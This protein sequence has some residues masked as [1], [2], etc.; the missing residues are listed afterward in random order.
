[1]GFG[2]KICFVVYIVSGIVR[3]D[4]NG[5]QHSFLGGV[6]GVFIKLACEP[7]SCLTDKIIFGIHKRVER[8]CFDDVHANQTVGVTATFYY[9]PLEG[10]Y[11]E[12]VFVVGDDILAIFK[13]I[14][15]GVSIGL[16]GNL[17]IPFTV[18]AE[19]VALI[20]F[21]I[22]DGNV[23]CFD[24]LGIFAKVEIAID[25][26]IGGMLVGSKRVAAVVTLAVRVIRVNTAWGCLA[27]DLR[28][29]A[30]GTDEL[31]DACGNARGGDDYFFVAVTVIA[32]IGADRTF[33]LFV[34]LILANGMV[35]AGIELV[36]IDAICAATVFTE[37]V[38]ADTSPVPAV[39]ALCVEAILTSQVT[40]FQF[41]VAAVA[42]IA[43][44]ASFTP[45]VGNVYR[46]AV[47]VVSTRTKSVVTTLLAK[48]LTA[49]GT[50]A[51][52]SLFADI[53]IAGVFAMSDT[54]FTATGA[55]FYCGN[56]VV[57]VAVAEV[58]VA[59]GAFC[60]VALREV[61]AANGTVFVLVFITIAVVI[62]VMAE[63]IATVFAAV[64]VTCNR[65]A[66]TA[67]V[68]T[69]LDVI[70]VRHTADSATAVWI[71]VAVGMVALTTGAAAS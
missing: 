3:A 39:S 63:E 28:I 54:F 1:M 9:H 60:M 45:I 62:E 14:V 24:G 59:I 38:S 10:L 17:Q 6:K 8:A 7:G 52:A 25:P 55:G 49:R 67:F 26:L 27:D 23:I 58:A 71:L 19:I 70:F 48:E 12:V 41:G 31:G 5:I 69:V 66:V 44:V 43:A 15:L 47:S 16:C 57:I 53:V 20:V 18:G 68:S 2:E 46:F 33:A 35:A 61:A 4:Y 65:E 56:M 32:G 37:A 13:S 30:N 64:V 40:A 22:G 42:D 29:A 34:G 36:V 21:D 50:R 11:L 51:V